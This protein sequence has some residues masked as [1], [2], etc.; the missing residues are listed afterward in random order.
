MCDRSR[1]R[2][3]TSILEGLIIIYNEVLELTPQSESNR[4]KLARRTVQIV[5]VPEYR[6]A[7]FIETTIKR[8]NEG[9]YVSVGKSAST[10]RINE[11]KWSDFA[12][13]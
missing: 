13:R 3:P 1:A 2:P 12:S 8:T 10:R 5:Q 11:S 4:N 7:H 9:E 6:Q